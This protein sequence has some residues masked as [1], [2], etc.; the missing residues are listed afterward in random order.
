M[1]SETSK[2]AGDLLSILRVHI[3]GV[4]VAAS[5]CFGWLF[6]GAFHPGLAGVVG[7]DWLLINLLNRATDLEE[8]L[9]N[10]IRGTEHVARHARL[11]VVVSVAVLLG[12]FPLTHLW[13]PEITAMRGVVQLIGVG[14]SYRIV[15]TLRGLR[16]FKDLYFFKNFMSAV[17]FV[18]T[19]FVYPLVVTGGVVRLPGGIWAVGILVLFFIPFELTYEI[20]YDLRDLEGDRGAGIPTYPVVHGPARTRQILGGLLVVSALALV[21]GL[22][23]GWIGIREGLMLF[24]PSVQFVMVRPLFQRGV[25]STDCIR[26]TN[27]G[28]ALLVFYLIGNQVWLGLG[29]PANIYLR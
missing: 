19:V 13:F 25:T 4:A 7:V 15:P 14:Y 5:L 6:S 29:M 22:A 26:L 28:T 24:A 2:I 3:L 27:F 8:D 17:L 1:F 23:L 11:F 10:G 12:S 9:A 16:R 18:L 21:V 20:L